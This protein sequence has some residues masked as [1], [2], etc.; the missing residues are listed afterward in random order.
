[1]LEKRN[2]LSL[3]RTIFV[4]DDARPSFRCRVSSNIGSVTLTEGVLQE[5]TG[6]GLEVVDFQQVVASTGDDGGGN[7]LDLVAPGD[8]VRRNFDIMP[9]LSQNGPALSMNFPEFFLESD[10]SLSAESPQTLAE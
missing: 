9:K 6:L 3:R 4:V 8:K 5:N 10:S 1:M 2:A 7:S